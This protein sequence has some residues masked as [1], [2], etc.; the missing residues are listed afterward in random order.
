[1][2]GA[3]RVGA[4]DVHIHPWRRARASPSASTACWRRCSPSPASSHPRL[5]NRVKVLAKLTLYKLDK[6][7]D[8]HFP[9]TTQEGP[10]DIRVSIL[11]TNHGEAVALRIARTA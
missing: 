4:S 1:M 9:F 10:A 11:P 7:Q 6:P 2:D 3:V 8:G 5:I